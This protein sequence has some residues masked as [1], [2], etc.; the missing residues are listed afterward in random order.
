MKLTL[1]ILMIFQLIIIQDLVKLVLEAKITKFRIYEYL[2]LETNKCVWSKFPSH[3]KDEINYG[4]K[5]KTLIVYLVFYNHL[6]NKNK[7]I[8]KIF[9]IKFNKNKSI[10]F[11]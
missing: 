10:Y 11:K 1:M 5:L 7:I 2:D 9:Q 6:K 4:N 3:I 8:P